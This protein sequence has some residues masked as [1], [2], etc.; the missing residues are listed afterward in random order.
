VLYKPTCIYTV[1]I[2]SPKLILSL[3]VSSIWQPFRILLVMVPLTW[4]FEAGGDDIDM[5]GLLTTAAY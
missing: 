2:A 3:N 5:V 4:F 1:H